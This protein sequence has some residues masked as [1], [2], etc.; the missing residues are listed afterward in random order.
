MVPFGLKAPSQT[1]AVCCRAWAGD[2][3]SALLPCGM[4]FQRA[5]NARAT[6]T[7]RKMANAI[8]SFFD[9]GLRGLCQG[10]RDEKRSYKQ[11]KVFLRRCRAFLSGKKLNPTLAGG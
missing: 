7:P 10:R 6:N 2:S 9:M 11:I 8:A 5:R 1:G 4:G 3:W